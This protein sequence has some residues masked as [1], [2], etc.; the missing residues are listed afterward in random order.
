MNTHRSPAAASIPV[1]AVPTI[2]LPVV[3]TSLAPVDPGERIEDGFGRRIS[4]LRVSL[5]DR[6][7]Y[8]CTY[9]MPAQG[10]D[11][12]PRDHLLTFEEIDRIVGVQPKAEI[13]RRLERAVG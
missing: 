5:T 8:R 4:Y 12:L 9:C 11:W 2:R 6:C 1:A 3:T 10:L 7:N 13:V